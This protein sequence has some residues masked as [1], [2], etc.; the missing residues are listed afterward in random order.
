MGSRR[1]EI[2]KTQQVSQAEEKA[3]AAAA[4]VN[5]VVDDAVVSVN[6]A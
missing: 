5:V 2:I 4:A 6:T 3:I 1:I